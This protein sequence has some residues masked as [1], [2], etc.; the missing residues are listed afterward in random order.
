MVR[1][2]YLSVLCVCLLFIGACRFP[3][4][5][6]AETFECY[7]SPYDARDT[8]RFK[9]KDTKVWYIFGRDNYTEVT[10]YDLI[11]EETLVLR[12]DRSYFNDLD[13][14]C[15]KVD[16]MWEKNCLDNFSGEELYECMQNVKEK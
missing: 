10:A 7:S 11:S 6:T 12:F 5:M 16:I 1:I 13:V 3:L 14:Q 2:V 15:Y 9:G 4:E 8:V